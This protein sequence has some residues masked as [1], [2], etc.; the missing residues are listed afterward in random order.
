MNWKYWVIRKM[1]PNSEK[2][3]T[4]TE[5][6]GGG[7]AR[8]AKEPMSSIGPLVCRSRATNAEQ[9]GGESEAA[10]AARAAPARSG[11]SMIV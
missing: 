2:K 6:L 5:P 10:D 8:Y 7:E 4:V 1:N 9:P 3:A 11:A